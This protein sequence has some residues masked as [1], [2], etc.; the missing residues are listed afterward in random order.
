[1]SA[2][3]AEGWAAGVNWYLNRA[4]KFTVD[5]EE[6]HFKGGAVAGQN[7]AVE[8]DVFTRFQLSF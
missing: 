7:R 4:L 8:R 6:T 5:Y 3:R 1:M 2:S